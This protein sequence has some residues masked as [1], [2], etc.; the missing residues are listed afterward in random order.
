MGGGGRPVRGDQEGQRAPAAGR[1]DVD[2]EGDVRECEARGRERAA[3]DGRGAEQL[4][5]ASVRGRGAP[6][7]VAAAFGVGKEAQRGGEVLRAQPRP[8][9][10]R[11]EGGVPRGGHAG[12]RREGRGVEERRDEGERLPRGWRRRRAPRRHCSRLAVAVH[13]TDWVGGWRSSYS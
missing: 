12:G 5:Q 1:D 7:V 9:V 13:L 3:A 6:P 11:G 8:E 4:E 10:V 2:G